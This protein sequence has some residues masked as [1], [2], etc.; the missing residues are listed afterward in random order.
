MK[1][2]STLFIFLLLIVEIVCAD[3]FRACQQF[4]TIKPIFRELGT[5]NY[6][7]YVAWNTNNVSESALKNAAS[8]LGL[9]N[10]ASVQEIRFR[11]DMSLVFV[12]IEYHP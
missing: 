5:T 11:R 2:F 9:T 7:R 12:R 1:I 6:L 10:A 4:R 8:E 3:E